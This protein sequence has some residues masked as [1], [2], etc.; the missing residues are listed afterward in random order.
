M[1]EREKLG[2]KDSLLLSLINHL[3]VVS[4]FSSFHPLVILVESCDSGV[5]KLQI[6][7]RGGLLENLHQ[8]VF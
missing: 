5:E 4:S 2:D 8:F 1:R 6:T 3:S 7:I